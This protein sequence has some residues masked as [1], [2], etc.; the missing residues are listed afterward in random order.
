MLTP[1]CPECFRERIAFAQPRVDLSSIGIVDDNPRDR[2]VISQYLKQYSHQHPLQYQARQFEDGAALLE[3]YQSNFDVIFLDIQME[4]IDGMRTAAAIRSVDTSVIIIFVT[5]TAQYATTG[6]TVQA[7]SYLLKPITYFA[8]ETE[9][10]R[11]LT[12]LKRVERESVLI[13]SATAQRRVDVIIYIESKRHKLTV[14]TLEYEVT[15]NGTLKAFEDLLSAR[16]FYR[17]NSGYLLN[18]Q[19][20]TALEGEEST[21]SNGHVLKVSRSRK[22]GLMEA[23]ADYIAGTLP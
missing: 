21:M 8:F 23:L 20:V 19:H 4:G 11:A 10:S 1:A 2:E 18:L 15:F 5:K 14:H 13:G 22:K 7:Q 17:S 12:Q 16:N 3:N 9:L 6:Y